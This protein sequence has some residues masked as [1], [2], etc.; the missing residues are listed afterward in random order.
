MVFSNWAGSIEG[1]TGY[2]VRCCVSARVCVEVVGDVHHV[3]P[4][5]HGDADGLSGAGRAGARRAYAVIGVWQRT[6]QL[7]LSGPRH[8]SLGARHEVQLTEELTWFHPTYVCNLA[9]G[10]LQQSIRVPL[11]TR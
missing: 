9:V 8:A 2:W 6:K 11:R 7:R 3:G 4:G 10:L 5:W 1:T